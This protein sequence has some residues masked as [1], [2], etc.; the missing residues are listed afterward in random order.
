MGTIEGCKAPN[1]S[2]PPTYI[3]AACYQLSTCLNGIRSVNRVVQIDRDSAATPLEPASLAPGRLI[4]GRG[5][6]KGECAS[7]SDH[8]NFNKGQRL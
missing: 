4:Q 3:E 7:S 8:R 6:C 5:S 1:A 2:G